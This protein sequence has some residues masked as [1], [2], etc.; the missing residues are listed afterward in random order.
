MR[1][2]TEHPAAAVILKAGGKNANSYSYKELVE[3]K[4][5]LAICGW[6]GAELAGRF[7]F[8]RVPSGPESLGPHSAHTGLHD[9]HTVLTPT[10]S[11][12]RPY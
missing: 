6:I 8:P 1:K 9:G 12:G 5:C 2:L 4:S 10:P 7:S 11:P 3:A